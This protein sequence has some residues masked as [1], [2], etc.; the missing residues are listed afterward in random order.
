VLRGVK[1]ASEENVKVK[2]LHV[3]SVLFDF[4]MRRAIIKKFYHT[5][6]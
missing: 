1:H 4:A 5:K 3:Y 2:I 6:N